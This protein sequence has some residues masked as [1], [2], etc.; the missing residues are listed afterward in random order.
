M[1]GAGAGPAVLHLVDCSL[2]VPPRAGTDGRARYGMLETLRAYGAG[3]LA[4]AGEQD[5]A[6]VA[7]AGYALQVAEEAAAGLQTSTGELAAA[8]RL[9]AEDATMRQ[10]LA[11]AMEHD[12]AIG[13]RLAVALAPWWL[14]RGRLAGEYP[15]LREMAGRAEADSEARRAAQFWLGETALYSADLTGALDHFTAVCDAVGDRRPS[16]ALADCLRGRSVTLTNLGRLAEAAAD[17]RRSLALARELGYPAGEALA[18]AGLSIAAY[19]RRRPGQRRAA[20]P[21][22]RADHGRHPRLCIAAVLCAMSERPIWAAVLLG[23]AIGN[24]EWAVL[25]VGPVLVA[26]QHGRLRA[27]VITGAVATLLLAPFVLAPALAG[28][29]AASTA[30]NGLSTG[31]IFQPW[32]IWWFFGPHG[33]VV[34]GL[35][36]SIT[37]GFRTPPAWIQSIGHPLVVLVMAPLTGLFAW[38][39]RR[40]PH[41]VANGP[42]LLLTLLFAL[43]CVL[44]PWDT[45][46]YAVPCL[47][48]LLTWEA[49]SRDRPPVLTLM[50]SFAAWLAFQETG[51]GA[52]NL[53]LDGQAL[54]FALVSVPSIIALGVRLYAPGVVQRLVWRPERDRAVASAGW[55][56]PSTQKAGIGT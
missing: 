38:L 21:A 23:M 14:L 16:R 39:R 44:D 27:L 24:K 28:A 37:A 31:T 46:Y 49:L 3:L 17:G 41:Q 50:A 54:V 13:L 2:L 10:V 20:G 7:L 56:Y 34:K 15:L 6:A 12:V 47:L 11:W 53:P 8:R 33:H 26:M 51:W 40:S 5:G 45:A 4:G 48:S 55:P 29:S 1:A 22:G 43:R 32:Q 19:V 35:H 36:D 42:L 18:L 30:A 25:A 52:L 9:D